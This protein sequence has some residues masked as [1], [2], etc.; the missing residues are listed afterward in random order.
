MNEVRY[1]VGS[2]P[3]LK[4]SCCSPRGSSH[5]LLLRMLMNQVPIKTKLRSLAVRNLIN[6]GHG[7]QL[8]PN[9]WQYRKVSVRER[10]ID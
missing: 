7:H 5:K 8:T 4:C 3:V 9:S 1:L 2:S 10:E 6:A